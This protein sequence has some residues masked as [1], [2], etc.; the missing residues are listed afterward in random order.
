MTIKKILL[1]TDG[2][3]Y[4]KT[5]LQYGIYISRIMEAQLAGLH[6]V[7]IKIIQ[8]PVFNDIFGCVSLS[9][10]PEFLTIIEEGLN[11]RADTILSDF[12]KQCETAGLLPEVKK[13][14]GIIDDE[15][16]EE[17]KNA[18]LIILAQRGEHFPI[19]RSILLGSTAEAVVRK[20]GKPV[21]VTPEHFKEIEA[22]G[23]AYDGSR[24]AGNAL[25]IAAELSSKARW[26]LTSIIITSD[27]NLA[28]ELRKKIEDTLAPYDIDSEILVLQGREEKEIIKFINEGAVEL[29][30]MGAYGHSRFKE[31]LLG[32]TTSYVIRNSR[33]PVLLTR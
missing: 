3:D 12:R 33:I 20:S 15:I 29:M 5:A 9:P 16:V 24:S 22:I 4:S 23:L 30:L 21:L 13:V 1:P 14:T 25:N 27:G 19:S 11:E 6:I 31:L 17:S 10:Y 26:P 18:D 2:S 7:D 28:A 8:G 32:S